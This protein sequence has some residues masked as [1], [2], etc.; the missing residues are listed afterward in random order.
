MGIESSY[1]EQLE[2]DNERLREKLSKK[3]LKEDKLDNLKL[4]KIIADRVSMVDTF[5]NLK[6]YWPNITNQT[7]LKIELTLDDEDPIREL[8]SFLSS[9][10]IKNKVK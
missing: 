9:N 10:V 5:Y 2:R 6:G 4:L 8:I 1:I 7:C 3:Q